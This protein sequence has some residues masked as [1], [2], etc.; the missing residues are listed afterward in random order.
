MNRSALT[1]LALLALSACLDFDKKVSQLCAAGRFDCDAGQGG[2]MGGGSAS[3]DAGVY[4][5]GP[6]F[7]G[8]VCMGGWCYENPFP[9]A[10]SINGIWGSGPNDVWY[11]C[12]GNVVM[13]WD[14]AGWAVFTNAVPAARPFSTLSS[15]WSPGSGE[16]WVA[17]ADKGPAVRSSSSGT[18]VPDLTYDDASRNLSTLS[19]AGGPQGAMLV[20]ASGTVA[21]RTGAAWATLAE[22][23]PGVV[24]S[25]AVP[26][27][28]ECWAVQYA[29]EST[30][31][32]LSRCDGSDPVDAGQPVRAVWAVPGKQV[33]GGSLE[34]LER[35]GTGALTST[36]VGF[37]VVGGTYLADRAR[38]VAV[39][40]EGRL[41]R[42]TAPASPEMVLPAG[43]GRTLRAVYAAPSGELFIGGELGAL[44]R[45]SG[46]S[47][48]LQ[49]GGVGL[50]N[51]H[52]LLVTPSRVMAVGDQGRT[53]LREP[54]GGWRTG[55]SSPGTVALYGVNE[56]SDHTVVAVGSGL[57]V[58][59][60]DAGTLRT[61]DTGNRFEGVFGTSLD[62][63]WATGEA[64]WHRD[65]TGWHLSSVLDGG[66]FHKVSGQRDG[67]SVWAVGL[68]SENFI[69]TGVAV[70]LF[71]DGGQRV[72]V[73]DDRIGELFGVAVLDDGRVWACGDLGDLYL[74]DT[75]AGWRKY[76]ASSDTLYDVFVYGDGDVWAAGRNMVVR[77]SESTPT[78]RRIDP[79]L[80]GVR[81]EAVRRL[82]EDVWVVGERGVIL[83]GRQSEL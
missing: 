15:V 32:I 50:T 55:Q 13:H 48:T 40:T 70:Q 71:A 47:Y 51:L 49:Q 79:A 43:D 5:F 54:G 22:G 75:D 36:P 35:S 53:L 4:T 45:G 59:V 58:V 38:W 14:G 17:T 73:P 1:G 27:A 24:V 11:A 78:F 56:L 12:S 2:G 28:N 68:Q 69:S 18:W 41:A 20:G 66:G 26:S 6:T 74:R 64:A 46:P 65:A 57:V 30:P 16:L 61:L 23:L 19:L 52:G 83:H 39:G 44:A 29:D 62:D 77:G 60:E 63:L 72:E 42:S 25:L 82:G 7:T 8:G 67:G 80:D 81:L 3:N 76:S 37:N 34:V 21:R 31:S 9:H 10:L 33:Y